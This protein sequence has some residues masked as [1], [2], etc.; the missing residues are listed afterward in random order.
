MT[1]LERR[2][3]QKVGKKSELDSV[4]NRKSKG[5]GPRGNICQKMLSKSLVVNKI[6]VG[7]INTR[8]RIKLTKFTKRH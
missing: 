5:N 7:F 6:C 1:T 4:I 8:E 3:G 2:R